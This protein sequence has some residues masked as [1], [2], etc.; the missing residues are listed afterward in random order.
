LFSFF[1]YL[2]YFASYVFTQASGTPGLFRKIF[3]WAALLQ[4][5]M[6]FYAI[7]LRINQYDLTI[8]RYLVLV[9]G[10]WLVFLSGYYILSRRKDLSMPFF[11]L[12]V[13]VI[14]MSI[15]PWSVYVLPEYRQQE[16]LR[17]NLIQAGMLQDGEIHPPESYQDV[18]ARLSGDI[19]GGIEYLCDFHGCESLE[20]IFSAKLSEI[21]QADK[22][23]FLDRQARRV[24]E[25]QIAKASQER[26]QEAR[27]EEYRGIRSYDLVRELAE[28]LKVERWSRSAAGSW[29]EPEYLRFEN[30]LRHDF[31]ASIRVSGYDH[32]VPL[33]VGKSARLQFLERQ[34]ESGRNQA[35]GWFAI[36]DGDLAEL[37]L[38]QGEE[39]A[40]RISIQ[41]NIVQKILDSKED[42]IQPEH[43][44]R[45]LTAFLPPEKMS[46]PIRGEAYDIK[47]VLMSVSIKNPDW[48]EEEQPNDPDGISPQRSIASPVDGYV[49][50]KERD[51]E[52]GE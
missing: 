37:V 1:G 8:N 39:V 15:G 20:G 41:G 23:E 52:A 12:L 38:Y 31:D 16:R 51:E 25:L 11:S 43:N 22:Q 42:Y 29:E 4:T 3:P 30:E 33:R 5:P 14:V 26:I 28:Y 34:E 18:D 27:S 50:I 24:E 47:V 45:W 9:F 13:V 40:E 21:R 49:L 32:Y 44:E 6:L 35:G 36:V 46:F 19:Y 48:Q 17:D 2:I 10:L 7:G